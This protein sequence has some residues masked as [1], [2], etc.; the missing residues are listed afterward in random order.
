MVVRSRPCLSRFIP[1]RRAAGGHAHASESL[2]K[3]RA[4]GTRSVDVECSACHHEPT[5]RGAP[6][7]WETGTH[8]RRVSITISYNR[9]RFR[10]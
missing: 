4:N 2:Q 8:K 6:G 10:A 5:H 1:R 3:L 9:R 7:S